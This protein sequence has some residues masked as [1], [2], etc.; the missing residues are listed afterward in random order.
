MRAPILSQ[1]P[2]YALRP[3]NRSRHL[4]QKRLKRL[5]L[6]RTIQ[7]KRGGRIPFSPV[8]MVMV[9]IMLVV[10]IMLMLMIVLVVVVVIMPVVVVMLI[11]MLVFMIMVMVM[12]IFA[13]RFLQPKDA[14]V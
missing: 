5:R 1:K 10:V 13:G 6:H 11:V 3:E 2:D 7:R 4:L 8:V 14:D 12:R 9:V